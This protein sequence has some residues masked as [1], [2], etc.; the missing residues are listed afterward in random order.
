MK[1]STAAIAVC[2]V[3]LT[4]VPA[5]PAK[6][7]P[8]AK[9]D[10]VIGSTLFGTLKIKGGNKYSHRGTSG[11]FRDGDKMVTFPDGIKGWKL[12]FK[13]GSLD[14]FKGRWYD[15]TTPGVAEIALENPRDDFE[16]IYCDQR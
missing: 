1:R 6:A 2:A 14:G 12:R 10:C 3:C 16:S 13:D 4:L 15:T 7:P 8:S 11:T 9:Y 5:A